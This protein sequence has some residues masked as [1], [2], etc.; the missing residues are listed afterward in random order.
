MVQNFTLQSVTA[1]KALRQEHEA[2]EHA[3][4]TVRSMRQ[5]GTL[6]L[7]RNQAGGSWAHYVYSQEHEAAGH[8]VSTVRKQKGRKAV[9]SSLFYSDQ[10]SNP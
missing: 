1:A 6:Y 2:A 9:L 10:D 7:V 8:T 5:L 3:L 4:S